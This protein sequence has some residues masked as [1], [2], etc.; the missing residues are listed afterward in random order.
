MGGNKD[1]IEQNVAAFYEQTNTFGKLA[2][3][4]KT[5]WH[6]SGTRLDPFNTEKTAFDTMYAISKDKANRS[7][8][9]VERTGEARI[10]LEKSMREIGQFEMKHNIFMTDSER[11]SC[12]VHNDSGTHKPAPIMEVAPGVQTKLTGNFGLEIRTFEAAKPKNN[13]KPKGQEGIQVKL[14]FYLK[15]DA[16]PTE[17]DCTQVVLLTKS[18]QGMVFPTSKIG[19]FYVGYARYFNTKKQMGTVATVFYGVVS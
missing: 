9:D 11:T 1:W 12:F 7:E 18:P 17:E 13:G 3:L 15:P 8:L 19:M 16:I 4:N 14:G 5:A 6:L 2:N 10:P